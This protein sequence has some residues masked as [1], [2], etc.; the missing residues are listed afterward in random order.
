MNLEYVTQESTLVVTE[1]VRDVMWFYTHLS[2]PRSVT[3]DEK[4]CA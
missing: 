2:L 3:K 1:T 4:R